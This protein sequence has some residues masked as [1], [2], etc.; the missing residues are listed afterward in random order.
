MAMDRLKRALVKLAVPVIAATSVVG[1][2]A[3]EASA[4]EP[5]RPL[6]ASSTPEFTVIVCLI[7][8]TD[9]AG[10]RQAD[11]KTSWW[12]P[13]SSGEYRIVDELWDYTWN[14]SPA[15]YEEWNTGAFTHEWH[16]ACKKGHLYRAIAVHALD[17]GLDIESPVFSC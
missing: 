11:V 2:S 10:N 5:C 16:W 7:M 4:T 8:Y 1:F 15:S 12:A 14:Y 6:Y 13:A 9:S 3:A 17:T